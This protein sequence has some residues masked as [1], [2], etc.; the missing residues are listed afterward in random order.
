MFDVYIPR[1]Y[2]PA[3]TAWSPDG[4]TIFYVQDRNVMSMNIADGKTKPV[5]NFKTETIFSL[6]TSADGKRFL[7]SRGEVINDVVLIKDF[8]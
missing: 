6:S 5:T 4:K 7:L 2:A 1:S 8:R 3:G